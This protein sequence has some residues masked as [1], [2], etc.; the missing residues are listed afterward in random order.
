MSQFD[1]LD[2]DLQSLRIAK[3]RKVAFEQ[4]AGSPWRVAR[5]VLVLGV[6][7]VGAWLG[8]QA[9]AAGR[10]RLVDVVQVPVVASREAQ[11]AVLTA[12]GYI[13]P[14]RKIQ[15]SAK[16]TGRVAA[17][18]VEKGDQVQRAQVLVQ[19][20]DAEFR[21]QVEEARGNLHMAEARL[22]ELLAG[23]RAQEIDQAQASVALA[24]A[25]W[26]N[27]RLGHE[28]ARQLLPKGLI[29]Q[30]DYDR[31]QMTYEVTQAQVTE[32]R[33]RY[34]LVK[35]GPR[36]EQIAFAQ[37]QVEAARAA[38]ARNETFLE[39]T[40]I[41]AP[42]D[43]T[44]LERLVEVGETVT[45]AFVGERGAKS[46]VV[47]LADLQDLQVELD[48]SQAD[49]N[50]LS[51]GQKATVVPEA[52]ADRTYQGQLAE[53]APEA[54]RQ[55]GTVQVKVTIL[56][57]DTYLRPEMNAKVSFLQPGLSPQA[58]AAPATAA[59]PRLTLPRAALLRRG[60]TTQVW[61][62][63]NATAVARQ[64]T[65]GQDTTQG[66]EV[67]E[68]LSGGEKVIVSDVERIQPGMAV[69]LK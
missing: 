9:W 47:S 38:V 63:Q 46:S 5:A 40:T 67:L 21:A 23:S 30:G 42:T 36:Q 26:R 34:E 7:A 25:N 32:A 48:I 15:L 3:D 35:A 4:R 29:A 1:S 41:K 57:P 16:I 65:L 37:A 64:V 62:V 17:V 51:M 53:I 55:K 43:G 27:A 18:A 54:N 31:A 11:P 59:T 49:F 69:R 44:I 56:N 66:V 22:Q 45:T 12:G 39:A 68:G 24:E 8:W 14:R 60:E 61:V 2:K 58:T 6:A 33:K 10:P 50:K 20:E 52:Y 19:L 13:I 28:R